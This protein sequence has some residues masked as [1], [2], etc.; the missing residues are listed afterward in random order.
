MRGIGERHVVQVVPVATPYGSDEIFVRLAMPRSLSVGQLFH[1]LNPA[2]SVLNKRL[3]LFLRFLSVPSFRLILTD[4]AMI[5]E[6]F[7]SATPSLPRVH[8]VCKRSLICIFLS[9]EDDVNS[10]I[11]HRASHRLRAIR[12]TV[13]SHHLDRPG[14]PQKAI[15]YGA[16]REV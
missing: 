15:K 16:Q 3:L 13:A 14:H 4:E 8:G 6:R 1:R 11:N 7:C 2:G 9:D 5:C 10:R 12:V